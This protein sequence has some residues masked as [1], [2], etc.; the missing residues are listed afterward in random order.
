MKKSN[1]LTWFLRAHPSEVIEAYAEDGSLH[2]IIAQ[3]IEAMQK[4][5]PTE[6]E[7]GGADSPLAE[8][9]PD[10]AFDEIFGSAPELASQ[11]ITYERCLCGFPGDDPAC[12][13]DH[14]Q[15]QHERT[16]DGEMK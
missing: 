16:P 10:A 3:Q 4:Q 11:P 7:Y 2:E 15:I 12:P 9:D 13:I 14:D 1:Q 8:R 6:P 5:E